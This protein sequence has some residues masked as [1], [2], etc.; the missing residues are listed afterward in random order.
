MKSR[1]LL[2]SGCLDDAREE[3]DQGIKEAKNA[4]EK[5]ISIAL[6]S[7]R[8][9]IHTAEGQ[10][11]EAVQVLDTI[12][13]LN[14]NQ[15]E[16]GDGD[17]ATTPTNSLINKDTLCL[18]PSGMIE[19]LMLKGDLLVEISQAEGIEEQIKLQSTALK[20]FER[21]SAL[22]LWMLTQSGWEDQSTNKVNNGAYNQMR[23]IGS[24]ET[25]TEGYGKNVFFYIS[26]EGARRGAWKRLSMY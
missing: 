24:G 9:Q 7:M 25:S 17:V 1:S 23:Y 14:L 22:S 3:C 11:Q 2:S 4:N 8:A 6:G 13:D 16:N 5:L 20:C 15:L 21:A 26:G 18:D 12:E 10:D 19:C